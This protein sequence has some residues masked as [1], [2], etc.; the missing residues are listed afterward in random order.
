MFFSMQ[1]LVIDKK[2]LGQYSSL[3]SYFWYICLLY[4]QQDCIL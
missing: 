3:D 1:W 2:I 4:E